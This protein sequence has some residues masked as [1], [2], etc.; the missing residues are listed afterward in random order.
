M[1]H[2]PG[3]LKLVNEAR[4]HI[5]EVTLEETRERLKQN[6]KAVLLDVREESEW[7]NGHAGE[8]AHL[9]KG[10][11]ERDLERLFPDP[12]TE[13]LMYCGGGY[14]SILACDAARR[15]G[16]K[17]VASVKGGFKAMVEAKW[18]MIRG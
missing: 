2:A 18:P 10:V 6:P 8:A 1:D 13:L 15:M 4:P 12:N 7:K 9:G 5:K 3:F 17:N 16:Y 14:R 11:L